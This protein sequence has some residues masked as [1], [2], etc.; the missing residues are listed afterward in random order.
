MNNYKELKVWQKAIDLSIKVYK[1]TY[2]FPKEEIYGITSQMRRSCVSIPSN[3]AEGSG[4][5]SNKDFSRFLDIAKGS[6]AEL[7]TQLI[8]ANH[9]KFL[10]EIYF[11]ELQN[12]TLEIQK[13]IFGLKNKLS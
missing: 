12:D 5:G 6:A 2:T 10:N 4:R 3:I 1:Y 11:K 8:I 13:M 9:L 7:D